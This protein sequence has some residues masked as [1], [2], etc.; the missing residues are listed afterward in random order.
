[1][2][3]LKKKKLYKI[4]NIQNKAEISLLPRDNFLIAVFQWTKYAI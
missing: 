2:T 4:A 1:M 3:N